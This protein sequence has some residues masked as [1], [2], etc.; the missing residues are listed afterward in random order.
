[1]YLT[2][3]VVR[4]KGYMTHMTS[5]TVSSQD[6]DRPCQVL[7]QLDYYSEVMAVGHFIPTHLHEHF[8]HGLVSLLEVELIIKTNDQVYL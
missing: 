8:R 3:I 5:V 1:M 4:I 2:L 6:K 7:H